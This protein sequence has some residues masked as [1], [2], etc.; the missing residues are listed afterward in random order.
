MKKLKSIK[1]IIESMVSGNRGEFDC[2]LNINYD[3]KSFKPYTVFIGYNELSFYCENA[4]ISSV[5]DWYGNKP[6]WEI[7]NIDY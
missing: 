4:L 5:V 1:E 3:G 2:I 6:I 7:T